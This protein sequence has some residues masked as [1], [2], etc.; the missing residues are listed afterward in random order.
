M[1]IRFLA[2]ILAAPMLLA[3]HAWAIPISKELTLSFTRITSNSA[4]NIENHIS[5]DVYSIAGQPSRVLFD[6]KLDA[7]APA[8][9]FLS[10]LFFDNGPLASIV[11]LI[12][13]DENANPVYDGFFA[14]GGVDFTAPKN[15]GPFSLPGGNTIAPVFVATPGLSADEDNNPGRLGPGEHLGMVFELNNQ[16]MISDLLASLDPA[17][18]YD[19][20]NP[21]AQAPDGFLR[22][23][24]HAQGLPGG[25]SDGFVG[26]PPSDT[27][28][29]DDPPP[30]ASN[31][32]EPASAFLSLL[33]MAGLAR[34]RQRGA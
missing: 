5:V 2:A 6:W 18:F 29:T 25:Q 31:L 28:P 16:V 3:C 19:V 21:P 7:A 4:V 26:Y 11:T 24:V 8:G 14:D 33:A 17:N 20:N 23:A 1:R 27:P 10:D 12:D 34:R 30:P 32:P 15:S 22:L 13:A 9:S